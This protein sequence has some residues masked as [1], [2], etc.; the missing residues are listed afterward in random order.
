[1]LRY[2]NL[3]PSGVVT[4]T[5]LSLICRTGLVPQATAPGSFE[6]EHAMHYPLTDQTWDESKGR[7][8][9]TMYG[10]KSFEGA[11]RSMRG[12]RK[13]ERPRLSSPELRQQSVSRPAHRPCERLGTRVSLASSLWKRTEAIAQLSTWH[14]AALGMH[15]ALELHT[16][17]VRFRHAPRQACRLNKTWRAMDSSIC[18]SKCQLDP[19]LTSAALN[20]AMA[21]CP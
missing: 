17:G 13:P 3:S 21:S 6:L 14:L 9:S 4:S 20:S 11:C 7:R 16:N 1:M 5:R 19:T 15:I 8:Q 12:D 18:M 2:C 10:D